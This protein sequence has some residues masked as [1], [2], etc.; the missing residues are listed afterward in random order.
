MTK[1]PP[2]GGDDGPGASRPEPGG[3]EQRDEYQK[4]IYDRVAD[5]LIRDQRQR[6]ETRGMADMQEVLEQLAAAVEAADQAAMGA[7]K[8][9]DQ[10]AELNG[11]VAAAYGSTV[12]PEPLATAVQMFVEAADQV[13]QAAALLPTG[14]EQVEAYMAAVSG[15]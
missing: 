11:V 6:V 1:W 10:I 14:K 9:H 8:L 2:L 12:L 15:G 13:E 4:L 7:A 3:D 5:R